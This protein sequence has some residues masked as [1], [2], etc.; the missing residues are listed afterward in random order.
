MSFCLLDR[1]SSYAQVCKVF[2]ILENKGLTTRK[3]LKQIKEKDLS[4]ILK[5]VGHRFPKQSAKFLKA[6]S[7]NSIDLRKSSRKELC[8]MEGIGM[9]LASMYLRTTQRKTDL[10]VLDIHI[11]RWLKERNLLGKTYKESEENFKKEAEKR[12]LTTSQFD[13]ILWEKMRRK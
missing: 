8:E 5:E 7:K 13:L 2:D 1:A 6:F 9:K 4:K 12:G 3:G 10:A 11:K